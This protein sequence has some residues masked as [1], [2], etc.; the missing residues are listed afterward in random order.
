[1]SAP[2]VSAPISE[3]ISGA[4]SAAD[5]AALTTVVDGLPTASDLDNFYL[6]WA[7]VMV[8]SMQLGFGL[9]EVGSVRAKN[10]VS[11]FFKFH[12][13]TVP[14][15]SPPVPACPRLSSPAL[16]ANCCRV[17]YHQPEPSGC[18]RWRHRLLG[19]R[20]GVRIWSFHPVSPSSLRPHPVL[21]PQPAFV[22]GDTGDS[23]RNGF[24][25]NSQ[26]FLGEYAGSNFD[27]GLYSAWFFQ[28]AFAAT[29][30][31]IVSG[32]VAERMQLRAYVILSVW[33]TAFVYPI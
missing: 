22:P 1:M 31:T 20:M 9:I 24:I 19:F 3:S 5:L 6:L 10:A 4:A 18:L 17:V 26:F 33:L 27:R 23:K 11:V 21:G 28:F 15:L 7:A 32:A 2:T 13:K 16:S 25:G 30:A 8:V 14:V 12:P 29:A